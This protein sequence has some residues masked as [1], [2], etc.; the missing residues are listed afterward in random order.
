MF[1]A[2]KSLFHKEHPDYAALVQQ[3][4]IIIDVRTPSEYQGGHIRGSRNIPLNMLQS[5]LAEIRQSNKP[6]I[7]VCRSGARSASAK[8]LLAAAGLTV[9]NGGA[10]NVLE[11]KLK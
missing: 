5:R 9:Y 7:T 10:W 11:N 4:A 6:V 8:S 1:N 2:I 3:G